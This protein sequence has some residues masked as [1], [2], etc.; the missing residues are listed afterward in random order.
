MTVVLIVLS[1]P[2]VNAADGPGLSTT[3]FTVGQVGTVLSQNDTTHGNGSGINASKAVSGTTM[4][5]GYLFVP[6][7][8]DHGGGKGAGAFAFYNVSDPANIVKVFDS[9]SKPGKYHTAGQL[10]YVGDWAEVHTMSVSGDRFVISE[11]RGSSAGF[12]IFDVSN[13][14]DN[15]PNTD[16]EIIGRYSYPNVTSASDYDGY[17]FSLCAQGSKYVYAPTGANGL[18]VVDISNPANP[19][20]VKH[21]A[22]SQLSNLTLRSGMTMGNWLILRTST[23]PV[24]NGSFVVMD[25]SDPANPV[26]IGRQDS[27]RIGYQGFLYG[28]RFFGG[29]HDA[30]LLSYDFS[31]PSNITVTNHN[32]NSKA[33]L[34]RAE[35]GF[36][37]DNQAFIGHYLGMTKW[38]LNQTP[39]PLVTTASPTNPSADDYAFLNPLGN[40]TV[41]C[42]DHNHTNKLNFA[43]HK[44]GLDTTAPSS[45]FVIPKNNAV[46][47]NVKSRV[48]IC[49]SD[50]VDIKTLTTAT[51]EV[52]SVSTGDLVAGS[53]NQTMNYVNFVP[54]ADLVANSSYTVTLMANGVADWSGNKVA[55]NTLLTTFSTGNSIATYSVVANPDQPRTTGQTADFSVTVTNPASLNLEYAWNYGDG[56]PLTAYSTATT[57]SHSYSTAGNFTLTLHTRIVDL[58]PVTQ[59][60]TVQIIHNPVVANAPRSSSTIVHDT[61][62]NLVWNVNPDNDTVT[63]IND[64]TYAKVYE[65]AVGD[66]PKTLALGPNN[67]LWVVNKTAASISVINRSMGTVTATYSLP[68]GS[69]PHAIVIDETAGTGYV[70]LEALK[71]IQRITT[72]TGALNG[73]LTV[74]D[75]PRYLSLVRS[76]SRL[77][78]SHFISPDSGGVLTQIN[79][80]TFATVGTTPLTAVMNADSNANGRG[81]PNYLGAM[82]ASPDA[83]QIFIPSK[84]DNIFRGLKRDG[85]PLTFEFT[86]RSIGTRLNLTTGLEDTTQRVDFDNSDM[87][88][89]VAFSPLGNQMFFTTMGSATIWAVD[90]YNV[91]N[92][93]TFNSGGEAPA[94]LTMNA[95]GTRLYVHNFMDRSVTVFNVSAVCGSVCGTA[96]Q[97]A[98]VITVASEDLDSNVLLGKQFFYR[99]NDARLAQEGYMSCASCHLDG[100][101]DGRNWDFTN[102]GEGIRNTIDLTGRGVG[103]GPLHWTANFDEVHDFEG[104]IR[105][106]AQGSGLMS[107]TDFNLSTRSQPLGLAKAGVSSDLDALAAY[108]ASL[109]STGRSPHRLANGNLSSDAIAG[110]TIF[111]SQNCAACH[112]GT[113]FSDSASLARHDVGTLLASSGQRLGGNLDGIDTPT[114]RGLWKTAPYLHDGSAATLQD[115]LVTKNIS[116]K[117]SNLFSLTTTEINQLVAYLNQIDDLET[118]APV[119]AVNTAPTLTSPGNQSHKVGQYLTLTLSASDPESDPLMYQ[120]TGLPAGLSIDP[121][122]GVISGTPSSV[123]QY[124]AGLSARDFAGNSSSV[125]ITWTI[126]NEFSFASSGLT[127]G[128]ITRELWTGITG[129]T[130]TSLTSNANYPNSPSS[131]NTPSSFEAPTGFAENYGTRMHGYLIPP[132][133]GAYTF[134][135]ASDDNSQLALSTN[136]ETANAVNIADVTTGVGWTNSQQWDKFPSQQSVSIALQAGQLYYIRALQK[137]GNGG[138]NLAVAWQGP[139]ITQAVIAGQYLAPFQALAAQNIAPVFASSSYAF[140]ISENTAATTAVGSVSASDADVGQTRSYRITGGNT[141]NTFAINSSTGAITVNAALDYETKSLYSLQVTVDDN[142][143]P[144]ASASAPVTITILNVLE[145]N[146]EAI[147]DGLTAVSGAFPG[148]ANPALIGFDMDPDKDGLSN[149]LELLLG[150]DPNQSDRPLPILIGEEENGGQQY[151]VYEVKVDTAFDGKLLYSFSGTSN[152]SNWATLTNSATLLSDVGG[153]KTFRIVDHIPVTA[154]TTRFMRITI[155]PSDSK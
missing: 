132:T 69:A 13:L 136:H 104:Q 107:N 138:D 39:A 21:M 45:V 141:S 146:A 84:K 7:S 151:A 122:T 154:S 130:V 58:A 33:S 75:W 93:F 108:V 9:R 71:Q 128:T 139:G 55:A 134:W 8:A 97:V 155:S 52:R 62:N 26:Q 133:T 38:D 98:K 140:S 142:G 82:A 129:S 2:L 40:A 123:N 95:T 54:T 145:D 14:Y 43:V 78:V 148:H 24:F 89:A 111:Q 34:D 79:T 32:P 119:P 66:N 29:S 64:S 73:T 68:S 125:S 90:A 28:S 42:S 143:S 102:F 92:S 3:P 100:G 31:D 35:Y 83:T 115:V 60:T 80:N 113:A 109:T 5:R 59:V 49:F 118:T 10:N 117:H 50:F 135:I 46:N 144:T 147:M 112:S 120:A 36:V 103:H 20:L 12:C 1:F 16:P 131:T 150:T 6:L 114:L 18:Y 77:W 37:I 152:L 91:N 101:H 121:N 149:A 61:A 22:K 48:G 85:N 99:T 56:T 41:I 124:T 11:R 65:T 53:F 30:D 15:D 76:R 110:K 86:V 72:A 70:S 51:I 27:I 47:Q 81:I 23:F 137:E 116:A 63:A 153:I 96:P 105:G 57:S 19:T 67:T 106:F 17:S 4:H 126:H 88:T 94:G 74:S 127:A 87:A 44:A 25:I